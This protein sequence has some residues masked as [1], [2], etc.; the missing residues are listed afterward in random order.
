ML[1][2]TVAVVQVGVVL[3]TLVATATQSDQVR[4]VQDGV[5]TSAQAER[6]ESHYE[7]H[8]QACHGTNLAGANAR[9]LAGEEFLR[10]WL[11]LT[12]DDMFERVRSMPPGATSSLGGETYL[13]LLAYL[14]SANGLPTGEEPLRT[15]T[16]AAIRVEGEDGPQPAVE[17]ALVQV[18]GCLIRGQTNT[19][20]VTDASEPI[21]TRAP[22]E[23]TGDARTVAEAIAPGTGAFELLYVY[24]SPEGLEGHRVET[25]GFLMRGPQDQINVTALQSLTSTCE[26]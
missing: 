21:R 6:G 25:K 1:P 20:L 19:W 22:D 13:E 15:E 11:G 4:T 23:S 5:Y 18:V 3:T 8:C 26:P 7:T 17:F 10:F 16:L 2:R 14:L 9:A 24:P 12:L